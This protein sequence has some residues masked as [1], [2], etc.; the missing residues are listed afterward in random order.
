MGKG[1][2][3]YIDFM[4][5]LCILLIV[6][7]HV[8]NA[9]FYD[10]LLPNLDNTLKSF[11]IPMYFFLSGLFFK[12]Y[13]GFNEFVRKKTNNLIITLL[14]FHFL[15]CIFR[16]PLVAIVHKIRP[17]ILIHFDLID[18]IPP[19]LGRFWRSAGALWFL[20][21]LFFVN[22]FFYLFHSFLDKKS[23]YIAVLLCSIIGY[24]LMKYK[25]VLPFEGDIA[26]VGLPY[27]LLGYFI[28]QRNL[29]EPLKYDKLGFVVFVPSIIFLYFFSSNISFI[30]QIVPNYLQL[31]L[32]PFIAILSL[33]WFCKNLRYV[34]LICYYGRYSVIIL[35]TH[36]I[37]ISYVY[38][39]IKGF[40]TIEGIL[41]S[42]IIFSIV[43]LFEYYIIIF[44]VKY[45]PRFTAQEEF[46]KPGWKVK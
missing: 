27:F 45:F 9:N 5:G 30:Y 6:M 31:Y 38:F 21:A 36:Q 13:S 17:D 24:T 43:I 20:V 46:F 34:P 1:R 39:F 12:T 4:K 26:L 18:V 32:V 42:I 19:F 8:P 11:R 16:F 41:F 40:H 44:M 10:T 29:L 15:C 2:I 3:A 37:L 33:F 28:K 22:I 14:F 25:I 23:V 35:G 7:E